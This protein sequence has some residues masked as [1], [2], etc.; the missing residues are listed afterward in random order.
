MTTERIQI[1]F[2]A[3]V[4]YYQHLCVAIVSLLENNRGRD[5]DIYVLTNDAD[6]LESEKITQLKNQYDNF[7][8]TFSEVDASYLKPFHVPNR[9]H[10]TVQTYYRFLIPVLFPAL[11]KAIYLD[12]D[13]IIEGNLSEL[14][15]M[16]IDNYYLA[17]VED[18]FILSIGYKKQLGISDNKIYINAG[19]LL[20]NLTAWHRDNFL[21]KI[22]ETSKKL[23]T[24]AQYN[25]QDVINCALNGEV[26]ILD[27]RFNWTSFNS[28]TTDKNAESHQS[29]VI[30]HFIGR[31][32]PWNPLRK[33][34]HKSAAKYFYYLN[35]TPYRNFIYSY[36][37]MRLFKHFLML[38]NWILGKPN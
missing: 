5:F 26:K 15:E 12:S 36:R 37:I 21:E 4:D 13:L 35:K 24:N 11:A 8:I 33:C 25:D 34:R 31:R 17:G 22:I 27:S 7:S 38:R 10:I 6:S 16:N 32:K 20:M 18:L 14:W 30:S 9:S 2:A 19:V 1:F 29:A 23:G 3:N 28:L